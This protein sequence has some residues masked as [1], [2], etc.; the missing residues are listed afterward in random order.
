MRQFKVT[1][2]MPDT[3]TEVIEAETFVDA[4]SHTEYVRKRLE[5][6]GIISPQFH[7]QADIQPTGVKD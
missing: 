6:L 7:L 2:V 1:Y 3:F 5:Q 4:I